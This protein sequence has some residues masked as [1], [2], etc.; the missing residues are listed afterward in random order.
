MNKIDFNYE[1]HM[2]LHIYHQQRLHL[3]LQTFVSTWLWVNVCTMY[4]GSKITEM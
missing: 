1:L 4:E 2:L 3:L